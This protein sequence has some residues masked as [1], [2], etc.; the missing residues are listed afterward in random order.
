MKSIRYGSI[1]VPLIERNWPEVVADSY[2]K[3]YT[4]QPGQ[5]WRE[6]EVTEKQ[7]ELYTSIDGEMVPVGAAIARELLS[8]GATWACFTELWPN[9]VIIGADLICMPPDSTAG[10]LIEKLRQAND[11]A[12]RGL[13]DVIA[14]FPDGR[15]AL[16]EAKARKTRDR[17]QETQHTMADVA[18][19][20][21]GERLDL[22]V[23]EWG[24]ARPY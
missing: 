3:T 16:R 23:V 14:S 10:E 1:E 19:R 24:E 11:G 2:R 9:L 13:P 15:V 4:L 12:L 8:D 7:G 20:V 21:F 5:H 17:L 18:R 6:A 22:A